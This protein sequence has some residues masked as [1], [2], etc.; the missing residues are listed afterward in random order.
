[1]SATADAHTFATYF[2]DGGKPSPI[3]SIPGFTHPVKDYFLED[4]FEIT[5]YY[6]GKSSKWAR[7]DSKSSSTD[8]K[9][10]TSF[11][12]NKEK[13]SEQTL[14]SLLHVDE[15]MINIDLIEHLVHYLLL[16]E[17]NDKDYAAD[18]SRAILIFVPGADSISKIVKCLQTSSRILESSIKLQVL[19]LHGGLPPSQQ[20][21]VFERPQRGVTKVVV[22]TNVAETSITI[23]DVTCVIDSGKA[24]EI[25]FD[26]IKGISRLQEVFVSQA[27]CQ[28][29]RGRAGRVK[30]GS[31]FKLFSRATWDKKL[32]KNTLPEI[33]RSPLHSLVMDTKAITPGDIYHTLSQMLTPPPADGLKQAVTLLQRMGALDPSTQLLTPLGMHLIKMPCDP[34]LGKML[35]FGALLRCLDPVLTIV[36]AQA[37]GRPVFWSSPETRT[38]AE[39]AKLELVGSNKNSKSDHIAIIA[40]YNGWR[41]ALSSAGRRAASSYCQKYFL[42]EQAMDSIHSGRRQ[43]A[44][45]LA[46]LGFI[47]DSYVHAACKSDYVP[48]TLEKPSD[49]S[50]QEFGGPGGVDEFAG[51]AK[52]VKAALASGFYPQ[53]VRVENPAAQFTKVQGGA[54]EIEG[55][56]TKVKF[57]EREKGVYSTS[58]SQGRLAVLLSFS[59][60][61]LKYILCFAGRVF[62]HPSSINFPCGKFE[63]GWLV[64]S[65][66]MQTSKT[67]VREC[68]MVSVY[69]VLLFGGQITVNHEKGLV[70]V[71]EWAS[72]KAPARIGVLIRELRHEVSELLGK[73]IANP[74]LQI[75]DSRI[76]EAMH[77]LLSTDGF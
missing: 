17:M 24:N 37:F 7:R 52:V 71:D 26:P 13:Y 49:V 72:F 75:S 4:I 67:F 30:P 16:N 20:N 39:K 5:G 60:D 12:L 43:F 31:C 57:F 58:P 28:Q 3:V 11:E 25:R 63:S 35:I 18:D 47:P 45:I 44:D 61:D 46:S 51:H 73:K 14:S 2:M 56:A 55:S 22:S 6:V 74:K 65:D 29:R 50:A 27:S 66:I 36:S 38:E 32:D 69:A 64:Y 33:S 41:A 76:I 62:I 23:D 54:I 10:I 19:P 15:K 53:L 34:K 21:K 1:M 8:E 40:A 48:P 77:H 70:L 68:S 9:S 59:Y 42:S